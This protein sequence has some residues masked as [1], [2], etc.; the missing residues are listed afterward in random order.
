MPTYKTISA[1]T[2]KTVDAAQAVILDVRTGMERDEKRLCCPHAHMPLDELDPQSLMTERGLGKDAP[3]YLVCRG[4]KWSMQAAE[5]FLAQGY[6]DVTVVEGGLLAC[7]ECGC[8]LEGY[9]VKGDAACCVRG[10]VSL[11]RQVR[12]A[13]GAMVV[14]GSV[15]AMTVGP[16]F[17][18]IPLFV[19]CGLVFAGVTDRCGLALVLTKAPWNKR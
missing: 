15:L 7:E 18:V 9:G 12:I 6:S 4:G 13:A 11:E 8:K 3:I 17:G 1:E 14:V 16:A 5:K 2:F 19:G 10:P